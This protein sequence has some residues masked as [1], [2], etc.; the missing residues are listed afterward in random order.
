MAK[1]RTIQEKL[2][3]AQQTEIELRELLHKPYSKPIEKRLVRIF[4]DIWTYYI[5]YYLGRY[6]IYDKHI[7]YPEYYNTIYCKCLDMLPRLQK[8]GDE[9]NLFNRIKRYF[10]VSVSGLV[11]NTFAPPPASHPT[12]LRDEV[13]L[14]S[15]ESHQTTHAIIDYG[16]DMVI[17]QDLITKAVKDYLELYSVMYGMDTYIRRKKLLEKQITNDLYAQ[18]L[19]DGILQ[20]GADYFNSRIGSI[21]SEK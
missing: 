3:L 15:I 1:K 14:T 16:I 13:I 12:F 20:N 2:D 5:K 11:H 7:E 19:K 10:N 9:R 4:H 17:V 21:F 8:L 18:Y 6:R